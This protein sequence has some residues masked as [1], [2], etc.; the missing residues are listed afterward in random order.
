MLFVLLL[1]LFVFVGCQPREQ[2]DVTGAVQLPGVYTYVAGW[3]ISDY[4]SAAGGYTSEA[5]SDQTHVIRAV[6][7]AVRQEGLETMTFQMADQ[8]QIKPR[9]KIVVPSQTY[10]VR[11]DTVRLVQEVRIE[12]EDEVFHVEKGALVTGRIDRGPVVAILL[13]RGDIFELPD[14]TE[15]MSVFHYLFVHLHPSEYNN[16][17][18]FD[19]G[20]VDS[21]EAFEDAQAIFKHVFPLRHYQRHME[22]EVPPS[23]LFTVI[24]G[25]WARPKL[26]DGGQMQMRKRRFADGRIWTTFPDG[27]HRWQYPDGR[28]EMTYGD[29]K[30]ETRFKDGRVAVS[31][32]NGKASAER[33]RKRREI[34]PQKPEPERLVRRLDSGDLFIREVDGTEYTVFSDG[35]AEVRF[36][37][38]RVVTQHSGGQIVTRT[39]DGQQKIQMPDGKQ[40]KVYPDG[41]QVWQHENGS[42]R[43]VYPDGHVVM[44]WPGGQAI[45]RFADGRMIRV[46]RFGHR[47]ETLPD[48]RRTLT[49]PNKYAYPGKIKMGLARVEELPRRV[50]VGEVLVVRGEL[51]EPAE[52]VRVA[53]FMLPDGIVNEGDLTRDGNIFYARF[54]FKEK[55]HC[56]VQ[57]QVRLRGANV[58]T[59]SHQMIEIGNPDPLDPVVFELAEYPG[60]EKASA[61]LIEQINRA[62]K[63]VKRMP[64]LPHPELMQLASIRLNEMIALGEVSHFSKSGL[65]VG[66]HMHARQLPFLSLGENVASVQSLEGLHAHWMLSAGHRENVL[67]K[68]WTHVGTAVTQKG[69]GV[70]AVE[71]FG[72]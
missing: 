36:L 65:G 48:G 26:S 39:A 6:S 46:N 43:L 54:R 67:Q 5:I 9:D 53:A 10:P 27:R 28:V 30:K 51:L 3:H 15:A 7:E 64:L 33:S 44:R 34:P 49:M 58:A 61:Y 19:R 38:G 71:I 25:L 41:R 69:G 13:G 57:V 22:A 8:P 4:V 11:W 31:D 17:A 66:W 20:V 68:D 50:E 29:G 70:W 47:I 59:V 14:T 1:C 23:G 45:E 52:K 35:G 63:K 62:R 21:L 2:V 72:R 24:P 16:I 42:S 55:G 12:V 40:L 56:R 32:T 60:D 18:K 37:D